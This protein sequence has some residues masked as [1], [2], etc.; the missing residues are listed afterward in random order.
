LAATLKPILDVAKLSLPPTLADA[1]NKIADD[2][3]NGQEQSDLAYKNADDLLNTVMD[4][5]FVPEEHKNAAATADIF[6]QYGWYLLS[7]SV[8]DAQAAAHLQVAQTQRDKLIQ[9]GVTLNNL[10]PQ[11]AVAA[12]P[13]PAAAPGAAPTAP[14]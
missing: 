8:G 14:Q 7:S 11:L 10:P 9:S 3:K 13:A 4:A 2:L 6:A 12:T 1:D 5:P